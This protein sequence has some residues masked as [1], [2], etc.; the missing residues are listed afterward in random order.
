MLRLIRDFL[1][2]RKYRLV[3]NGQCSSWMDAQAEVPQGSILGNLFVL[4]YIN[5]LPDNLTS[6]LNLLA[7]DTSLFS[8]V[9]DP[10]ATANQI[11]ND[12][13][14]I[15]KWDCHWKKNFNPDTSKQAQEVIFSC[16]IKGTAHPQIV[17]NNNPV[18]ETS[19]QK[20]LGIFL[21]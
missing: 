15:N 6:N 14:D 3:L 13:H 10:N 2:D 1:S 4:I 7:G 5:E 19:T 21:D 18:H 9:T 11:N 16:G 17:F 8:T 20:H 12:L